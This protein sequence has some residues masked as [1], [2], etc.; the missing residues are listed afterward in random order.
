MHGKGSPT[1]PPAQ[2]RPKPGYT[3]HNLPTC[4]SINPI[5]RRM[6][7]NVQPPQQADAQQHQPERPQNAQHHTQAR[8]RPC[9]EGRDN[10]HIPQ[11]EER[12]RHTSTRPTDRPTDRPQNEW[13]TSSPPAANSGPET[14]ANPTHPR[15][16]H[17]FCVAIISHELRTRHT[18]QRKQQALGR[19]AR[20]AH[21]RMIAPF[22]CSYEEERPR[23][24][25]EESAPHH[26][27]ARNKSQTS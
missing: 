23:N 12:H 9:A 14:G 21:I 11:P 26:I 1:T 16:H 24:T 27:F 17:F 7:K 4:N 3:Q 5:D 19:G 18:P 8:T 25:V 10:R 6:Q 20:T 13:Q 2:H 22:W 15:I